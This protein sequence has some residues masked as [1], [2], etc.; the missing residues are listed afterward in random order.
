[1]RFL[2]TFLK[3]F[4]NSRGRLASFFEN[5]K[6]DNFFWEFEFLLPAV[7]FYEGIF[8]EFLHRHFL[9]SCLEDWMP[10]VDYLEAREAVFFQSLLELL[11]LYPSFIKLFDE[12]F[13]SALMVFL[14]QL[15]NEN[16]L[17]FFYYYF[18]FIKQ[19]L[20]TYL[21]ALFADLGRI[22]SL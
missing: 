8:V 1:M 4:I 18:F 19:I 9:E 10:C 14:D 20:K 6:R 22:D 13:F 2:Y 15:F 21:M 3:S 17:V 5:L 12:F 7:A 16:F 11:H